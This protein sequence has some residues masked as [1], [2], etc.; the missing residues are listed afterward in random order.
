MLPQS[1][2][3]PSTSGTNESTRIAMSVA[4]HREEN[5][6]YPTAPKDEPEESLLVVSDH[7]DDDDEIPENEY[8]VERILNHVVDEETGQLHFQIKWEGYEKKSDITWEP[9][10][11]LE[12][13]SKI[14]NEYL[15]S[16]GGK[17]MI[18][19]DWTE[20]KKLAESAK[21]GK[22]RARA[23][24]G[25]ASSSQKR[26]RKYS[27]HPVN[28]SPPASAAATEFRPPTGSWEE[29]VIKIDACEGSEGNVIVYLT[30]KGGHKSQHPLSQ[31]YKRCPQKM[32]K[33]YEAHLVFKAIDSPEE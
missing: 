25:G 2:D 8:I 28:T 19:A 10:E 24:T 7:Q 31:I 29:E 32:L 26:S 18:L 16:V 22:K 6:D 17:D 13:A 11:N 4:S 5:N 3:E 27:P 30:W 14:L 1:E 21:K 23:S 12:T 15:A 9:E 33:F 20:K